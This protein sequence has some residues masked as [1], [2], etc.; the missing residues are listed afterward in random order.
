MQPSPS[1]FQNHGIIEIMVSLEFKKPLLSPKTTV[2]RAIIGIENYS[3]L[4]P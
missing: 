3:F 2:L 1:S 4:I